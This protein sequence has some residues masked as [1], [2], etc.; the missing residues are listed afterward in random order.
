M[1]RGRAGGEPD[2]EIV[3]PHADDDSEP[4]PQGSSGASKGRFRRHPA[5]IVPLVVVLIAALIG[6]R[7]ARDYEAGR[8]FHQLDVTWTNRAAR[9]RFDASF[10]AFLAQGQYRSDPQSVQDAMRLVQAAATNDRRGAAAMRSIKLQIDGHLHKIA[11]TLRGAL[12]SRASDAEHWVGS[13]RTSGRVVSAVSQRLEDERRQAE[14]LITEGRRRWHQPAVSARVNPGDG[15]TQSVVGRLGRFAD[16]STGLSLL[17]IDGNH[18]VTIDVDASHE[19]AIET[20]ADG[21]QPLSELLLRNT[22]FA[23]YRVGV[24]LMV[25]D[26]AKPSPALIGANLETFRPGATSDSLW[27]SDGTSVHEIRVE[28]GLHSKASV[29]LPKNQR[30]SFATSVGLIIGDEHGQTYE[31]WDPTTGRV[32]PIDGDVLAVHDNLA[33]V[34]PHRNEVGTGLAQGGQVSDLSLVA[35]GGNQPIQIVDL[36]TGTKSAPIDVSG[37]PTLVEFSPDG[38]QLA[39]ATESNAASVK[40]VDVGTK[41]THKVSFPTPVGFV[42]A[43]GLAWSPDSSTLVITYRRTDYLQVVGYVPASGGE[44][45]TLRLQPGLHDVN[46]LKP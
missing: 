35:E 27:V 29:P 25:Q 21:V 1:A 18:L 17:A 4:P 10:V 16:E 3:E 26:F 36:R 15:V 39:I 34:T 12:L 37:N 13:M 45:T 44:V 28:N 2:L 7:W 14:A 40:I 24:D 19:A 32:R 9:F 5:L 43:V 30:L 8:L 38:Q 31:Q 33:A 41:V 23:F 11:E 42:T 20:T 46:V 6:A 22:S